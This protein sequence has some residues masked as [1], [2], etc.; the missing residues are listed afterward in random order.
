MRLALSHGWLVHMSTSW[1]HVLIDLDGA[2]NVR[3]LFAICLLPLFSMRLRCFRC[4]GFDVAEQSGNE[5]GMRMTK[6]L[7]TWS[8]MEWNENPGS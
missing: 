2:A 3:A 7:E 4:G 1:V 8:G 6:S 5:G